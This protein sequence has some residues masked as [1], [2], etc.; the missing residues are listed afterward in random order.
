MLP[1]RPMGRLR[2]RRFRCPHRRWLASAAGHTHPS[3]SVGAL[4][5]DG[6]A[7]A[8]EAALGDLRAALLDGGPGY[9]Y[10][11]DVQGVLGADYLRTIYDFSERLH[12]LPIAEKQPFLGTGGSAT[13]GAVYSGED[14][15]VAEPAYDPALRA[16]VRSW[17]YS[18]PGMAYSRPGTEPDATPL[19]SPNPRPSSFP[20]DDFERTMEGL[21]DRQNVVGAALLEAFA[22]M[23]SL[24]RD[25]FERHF[26]AGD[27]GTIR[28]LHYPGDD[29][30]AAH[31]SDVGIAPHTDFEV[32]TLMHQNA[33]GLQFLPAAR[34][35][36]G[37]DA[38]ALDWVDAP[39][40]PDSF[41]VIIGPPA[42]ASPP[43]LP[44][45]S[46]SVP[47]CAGDVLERWS[48][49]ALRATPHRVLN[50]APRKS[51]IRFNATAPETVIEPLDAF[52]TPERPRR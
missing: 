49:G 25:T 10:A 40:V 47:A 8:R 33:P 11:A 28:L 46:Q 44:Q 2:A 34:G 1:G 13:A 30:D 32:F 16:S 36:E 39:V 6:D 23:F 43:W 37:A 18:R 21:Y 45:R 52:V 26:S 42:R 38:A 24:P 27:M 17:D 19:A 48:N 20:T 9:F 31:D 50:G 4:L 22:E 29:D 7:A 35:E 12:T 51:I 41:V 3:V 5:H 14:A 15:G